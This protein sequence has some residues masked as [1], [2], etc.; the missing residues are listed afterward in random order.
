[1]QHNQITLRRTEQ[2]D[3]P[4]LFRFQLDQQA[5]YLAAFTSKDS[6]NEEAYL[7]KFIPFLSDPTI[8]MQ[9]ILVG[10]T[11]VGSIAKFELLGHA[12][13]TYWLDRNF[14]GQGIATAA[15][16]HL[17]AIE[18]TRPLV[19][20]V[21]FDNVGSQRVLEKC[22]FVKVGTDRGFAYA[23]QAEIEEFIYQLS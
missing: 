9:T 19:G 3:L 2:A 15:L 8:N 7:K 22:G 21:A 12:E 16:R 13:L 17:L 18:N 20:R 14:W 23:R 1:M 4:L 6:I 11:I 5:N 10:E